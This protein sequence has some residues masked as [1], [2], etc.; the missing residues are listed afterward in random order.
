MPSIATTAAFRIAAAV[1]LAAT[2]G[3]CVMPDTQAKLAQVD[4]RARYPIGV[5]SQVVE[6][7]FYGTAQSALTPDEKRL[8]QRFV[9]AYKERGQAPITVTLGGDG[10][11]GKAL[12]AALQKAALAQGL[13]KSEVLI[14]VD[15]SQPTDRVQM[16]FVSYTAEVPECGYWSQ[17]SVSDH[18]NFNSLNFGCA[19]QHNLGLM[20]ADPSDLLGKTAMTPRNATR[21]VD[22]IEQYEAGKNPQGA[23]PVGSSSSIIDTAE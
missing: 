20:L 6:S 21:T 10:Q 14:G 22:G 4:Y 1:L 2:A 23:W 12:A 7:D 8:L 15:P 9:G 16:S 11:S 13:A 5:K 18:S 19:S 3:A 17:S